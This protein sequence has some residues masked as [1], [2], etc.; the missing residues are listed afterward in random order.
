MEKE[1]KTQDVLIASTKLIVWLGKRRE[2]LQNEHDEAEDL[3]IKKA[4]GA[5]L[6]QI[7]ECLDYIHT[8]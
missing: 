3:G 7:K 6:K 5:K 2:M 4:K 8:H 1:N